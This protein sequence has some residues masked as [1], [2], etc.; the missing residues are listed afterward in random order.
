M[1]SFFNI[2]EKGIYIIHQE[3]VN[4]IKDELNLF[5]IIKKV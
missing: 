1:D 3:Y 4:I 5:Q 2:E